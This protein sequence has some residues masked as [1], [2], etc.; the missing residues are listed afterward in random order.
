M[1][2]ARDQGLTIEERSIDRTELYRADEVFMTGT[3]AQV[4]PVIE[5]DDYP[6]NDKQIGPVSK[7]LQKLYFDAVRGDSEK[8]KHWLDDVYA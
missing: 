1:E 2:I 4:A 7:K 8:Y 6:L 5:I 3:G